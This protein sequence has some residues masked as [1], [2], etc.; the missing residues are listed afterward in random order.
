LSGT[1]RSL[2]Q[3]RRTDANLAAQTIE[4]LKAELEALKH[5]PQAKGSSTD[6]SALQQ[7][8]D[9]LDGAVLK[10][11]LVELMVECDRLSQALKAEQESHNQTRNS[12]TVA[13]GDT[14]D[15]LT[16]ERAARNSTES[17]PVQINSSA[18]S[19]ATNG[20]HDS[21]EAAKNPS[22]ELPPLNQV[23]S[24]V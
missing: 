18:N 16:K 4:A 13:L 19:S 9:Q 5:A 8:I 22:L 23:Q 17:V 24:L 6:L 3:Q 7:Q 10:Q 15:L 1:G 20:N 14:V 12:L 11:R 21:L 2:C